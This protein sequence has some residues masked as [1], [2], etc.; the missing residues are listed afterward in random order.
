ML[1]VC[2]WKQLSA[3]ITQKFH[4]ACVHSKLLSYSNTYLKGFPRIL[5]AHIRRCNLY[6]C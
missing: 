4:A 2:L 1:V 5:W 3:A 6:L